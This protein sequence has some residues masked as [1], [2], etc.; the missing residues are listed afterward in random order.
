MKI[1][2]GF[3]AGVAKKGTEEKP[4]AM[5][6]INAVTTDRDGFEQTI[7]V[8]FMVAGQQYKDGLHNVYRQHIGTEVFAP[9][10]DEIDEFNGKYRIRYS[11]QGIPL[12][13][14]DVPA[15][16]NKPSAVPEQQKTA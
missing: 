13:L 11:L 16:T 2:R 9:Y 7:L 4:W 3:V 1:L 8:K 15:Q 12:R 5:V 14:M 10:S 6:G